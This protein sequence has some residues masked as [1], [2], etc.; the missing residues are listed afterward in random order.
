MKTKLLLLLFLANF[1][2]YAQTNL[3]PNPGFE[4][5]V[6][7][8]PENWTIANTVNS[9]Y[10]SAE[11][12]I[13]A[14][15][16]YT[17]QSPKITTEI[18]L[19]GGVTYTIKFKYRYLTNN[20]DGTHPISLN[21]SKN[22]SSASLSS[23]TFATNNSWTEKEASFT[24]DVDLSYDLSI[25]TFSFDAASFNVLIDD[26]QVYVQGTEQ[27]TSIPDENFEKKL[28]ELGFDSDTPDGR[29][30]TAKIAK[31]TY[32]NINNSSI[33]DLTGI[34]DFKALESLFAGNN[35]LTS[36]NVSNNLTLKNLD[37][38]FN[39]IS[40]LDISKNTNLVFLNCNYNALPTID[41][42]ANVN[43]K[44]INVYS[45]KLTAIDISK[46][47]AVEQFSCG[48][49]KIESLD[50]SNNI[51]L[52]NLSCNNNSLTAL[53]ISKNTALTKLS[54]ETNKIA[55]LDVDQNL[56]LSKVSA[57]YN[58]LTQLNVSKNIKLTDLEVFENEI[59]SL[60]V[61]NNALLTKLNC[62]YNYIE[63][64][65]LSKNTAL[66]YFDCSANK[67]LKTL[68]LQNGK[69]DLLSSS[70]LNFRSNI[71]LYCILVDDVDYANTNWKNKDASVDYTS[72]CTTPKYTLIPDVEF[73][74]NLIK[75]AIDYE[76][77]GKVL[78]QK[79]A[80]VESLN[81]SYEQV[82]DLTGLEDFTALK[83]FYCS[84]VN[85]QNFDFSHNTQLTGLF[86]DNN[87]LDA[88]DV[89]KLS[90]LQTL[91]V[92]N[93][94][95][96][97]I[98]I[99]NNPSL[100]SLT[101]K[102]N[103]LKD[104]NVSNN[105]ELTYLDCTSNRLSTLD[106]SNNQ[107][108]ATLYVS[109]NALT[110][111]D[112]SKNIALKEFAASANKLT[113]LN[114]TKNTNLTKIGIYLN[115]ISNL[116]LSKNTAL[117]S[118]DCAYNALTALDISNN[119]LLQSL[120]G[121]TNQITSLDISQ[122]PDLTYISVGANKFKTVNLKNGN[123]VKITYLNLYNNP[124]L[125]CIQVD[126]V[127]Y[128][129]ANWS[130]EKDASASFNSDCAFYTSIPDTAF[131]QKLIDLGLDTDGKNGK[132]LTANISSLQSL[133]VSDSQINDLTGIQ[134]F[135]S[136]ESLNADKN[137]LTRVD[138]SK[139]QNLVR[140]NIAQNQLTNLN[141]I[142][143]VLLQGIYCNNNVLKTLDLSKNSNLTEIYCPDNKLVSLNLK[144]GNNASAV[145]PNIK[146][147]T[148]N[149]D[150]TCIQVDDADYS[151]TNWKN[152]KDATANYNSNCDYF[153]AIPDSKFEA[154]LIALGIDK[155]GENGKVATSSIMYVTELDLSSSSITNLDGIQDFISLNKLNA[156][157]NQ[158][159]T[160]DLSKNTALTTLNV[161][162]NTLTTLNVSSN[163]YLTNL[164]VYYNKISTLDISNNTALTSLDLS[165][166]Q[167]NSLDVSKLK[168]LTYLRVNNNQLVNLNLKNGKNELLTN[169]NFSCLGNS[170]LTCI[171][172]DDVDYANTNWSNKKDAIATYNTECTGEL[173]LPVDNFTVETKGESC[174]GENNGEINIAGKAS[175]G[176]SATINDKS[177]TFT[178]NA[179]Q[180]TSL[181]PGIYSI[182]ITIPDM[183]FEQ[184]FNV[185]I[186]KGATI[187]GK[188]NVTSKK[189]DVEITEGTA[190]F[191]VF[192]D[193][194][195]QF[196]TTDT[197]F[198]V[199]VNKAGLI[200]VT[201]AKACEGVFAKKVTSAELGTM[202]LAYPNP[203]YGIIEIEIPGAK[204]ETAIELYN[205]GGQLVSKRTYN[206]E[207]GRALLN[208]ENLPAGI[209]A[210][211]IYLET[212]EYIKI[213]KK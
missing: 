113:N 72:T 168:G 46:N 85:V 169:S 44:D 206:T 87:N 110:E 158:L 84:K 162:F 172:V 134:D 71:N 36:I 73:E 166:N 41:V 59:T 204:T 18:A 98:D 102:E 171:L 60:D 135:I 19:K 202:L 13:S 9:S 209:Y 103:K 68:N 200:E 81:L 131:E 28:I 91:S 133:D 183:I 140:L 160:L 26:V 54:I 191:T 144:N 213:I 194:T 196:Q 197:N 189:V 111:I 90:K 187:T 24:P 67:A 6:A 7:G 108:L 115:Q 143:N 66:V 201:T 184:N 170:N 77:D 99:S 185:T 8:V 205:F 89:S 101:I 109:S 10:N 69:N 212:P 31:V 150:L 118:L 114:V 203:T 117:T 176:Y 105:A 179:L 125:S 45:N 207:S 3:V 190:P 192:I 27:Y 83:T 12:A 126:D 23:S 136:L 178:N 39:Q 188:S 174:L 75:N 138:L 175:F 173:V 147:F 79:I 57:S 5:W 51:N 129:T 164:S 127:E 92:A 38:S 32:L 145:E 62:R 139:N 76:L 97:T 193:G 155:D 37:I 106:V 154:K 165:Y 161:D 93:N 156:K 141:L 181:T 20:F 47:I 122:N 182:K 167:L 74:K 4:T 22:G 43:L 16:S 142:N 130:S 86:L 35:K 119:K 210:A 132:V 137:N 11:G 100:S 177:Y 124:N 88:I 34:E 195:E 25:S 116:N 128:A 121:N 53:N 61:S 63:A 159:T 58:K 64:L 2:F 48:S 198:S 80:T 146:N 29:V 149:P 30:Q 82:T 152:F 199:D 56:E 123:N 94:N 40:S 17:T 153:T 1:S 180:V 104:L 148:N 49:N 65:D 21:I 157:S 52:Q 211:K 55:S 107:K 112:L 50:L 95:L 120:N 186:A 33:S 78:T 208:L 15:L 163:Q 70:Y 14:M 96:T 42:S 151:N